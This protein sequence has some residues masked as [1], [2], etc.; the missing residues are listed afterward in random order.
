M[1]RLFDEIPTVFHR[2]KA[3]AAVVHGPDALSAG[4]RGILR[5]LDSLELQSVPQLARARPV[6]RQHIQ[7]LVTG[8]LEDGLISLEANP[9]HRKSPLLRLTAKGKRHLQAIQKRES[10]LLAR[11]RLDLTPTEIDRATNTLRSVCSLF[12]SKGW[13]EDADAID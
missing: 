1:L 7:V 5:S 10:R 12:E 13:I 9:A 8:L 11:A 6:S 4:R 2:L 3:V